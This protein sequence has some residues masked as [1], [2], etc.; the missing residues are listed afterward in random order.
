MEGGIILAGCLA[1]KLIEYLNG[2]RKYGHIGVRAIVLELG[3][4]MTD[5]NIRQRTANSSVDTKHNR[6]APDKSIACRNVLGVADMR[7]Q[8]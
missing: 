1:I 6:S 5:S 7:A 4:T 3:S 2:Q 8:R